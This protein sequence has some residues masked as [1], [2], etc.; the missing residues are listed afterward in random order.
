[1]CCRSWSQ[2]MRQRS[3][4]TG[5]VAPVAPRPRPHF[6]AGCTRIDSPQLEESTNGKKTVSDPTIDILPLAVPVLSVQSVVL[7]ERRRLRDA[8]I[9]GHSGSWDWDIASGVI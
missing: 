6:G 8:E 7:D 2:T 4:P 9:V 5:A 3:S 1:M